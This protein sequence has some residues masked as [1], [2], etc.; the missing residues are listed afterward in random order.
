MRR[1]A[2]RRL[3]L[4]LAAAPL[5]LCDPSLG[6]SDA[7]PADAT[8]GLSPALHI[9]EGTV[10]RRQVVAVSRDVEVAGE[11]LAD[12]V[13]LNGGVIVRGRVAGDVLALGGDVRL[14][15]GSRVEGDVFALGG[16]VEAAPGA[17]IG[18]RTVSHPSLSRAWITLLEG[19]SLGLPAS[20]PVVLG[21]KLALLCGWLALAL[22]LFAT[23]GREVVATAE[24]VAGDPFRNFVVGLT[25]VLAMVLT[26]LLLTS[27][28]GG[29]L[30]LP[31]LFLVVFVALL[32]KLW[33]MV[34]VFHAIGAWAGRRLLR[35]R[36]VPLNALT[37]G[38]LLLGV[39]KLLPWV[40]LWA[41]TAATFI[42]VGAALT[43]KLGR[44]EPWL[45]TA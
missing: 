8:P 16:E 42:G 3:L 20:S 13:A 1:R 33:G 7:P 36:L 39:V 31:L 25:A 19:P 41:W 30:A 24:S 35:L 43:T 6:A 11:A 38:L 12:V 18:G 9:G 28:A 29:V 23:S 17:W 44:S 34:A 32:L 4:L 14:A 15:G 21:A 5:L 10:A 26:A 2:S 27:L 37:L 45:Q 40:G 22:V